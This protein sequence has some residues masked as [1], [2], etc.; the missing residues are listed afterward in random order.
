MTIAPAIEQYLQANELPYELVLHPRVP[1]KER[2][3]QYVPTVPNDQLAKSVLLEDDSG[4]VVAVLSATRRLDLGKLRHHL[5]RR[6]EL[7]LERDGDDLFCDC[8]PGTIPA[9]ASAYHIETI[10]DDTLLQ[11]PEVYFESGDVEALIHM[12]GRN[13]RALMADLPHGQ[14]TYRI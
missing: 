2:I 4:Y 3:R 12:S 11:Q 5:D 1:P 9:L 10:V 8:A 13:F 6:I 14:F 7:T